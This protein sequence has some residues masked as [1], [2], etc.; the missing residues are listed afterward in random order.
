MPN[1][2]DGTISTNEQFVMT[3]HK[4]NVYRQKHVMRDVT[5]TYSDKGVFQI[6]QLNSYR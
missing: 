1:S 4:M 5:Y 3:P 6:P 2:A